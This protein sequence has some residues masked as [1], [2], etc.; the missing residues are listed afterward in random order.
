MTMSCGSSA[1]RLLVLGT[2]PRGVSTLALLPSCP[3]WVGVVC[4][5]QLLSLACELIW[6][7]GT[8]Q[9]SSKQPRLSWD[10][11]QESWLRST[12]CFSPLPPVC[13]FECDSARGPWAAQV[14]LPPRFSSHAAPHAVP[15]AA[16][17]AL[18]PSFLSC[19]FGRVP[20][21]GE[22]GVRCGTPRRPRQSAGSSA[23][24]IFLFPCGP[25]R[26]AQHSARSF[27]SCMV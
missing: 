1:C 14:A 4:F 7:L 17:V 10:R 6:Q 13:E 8:A 12:V 5:G 15:S 23:P 24:F 18:H 26:G 27:G 22:C 9:A 11:S 2:L 20:S 16:R 19:G 25:A 21:R 3:M